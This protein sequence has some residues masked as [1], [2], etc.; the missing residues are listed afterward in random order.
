[1]NQAG[2]FG[3]RDKGSRRNIAQDGVVPAQQHFRTDQL[4]GHAH[5]RLEIQRKLIVFERAAQAAFQFESAIGVVLHVRFEQSC[6]VA[7][8]LGTIH[9]N[10]GTAQDVG[11]ILRP[12]GKCRHADACA[13]AEGAAI[14]GQRPCQSFNQHFGNGQGV[15]GNVLFGGR[16]GFQQHDEL[17]AAKPRDGRSGR[18]GVRKMTGDHLK[19]A[20]ADLMA[21]ASLI[22]LKLSRSISNTA[23]TWPERAVSDSMSPRMTMACCKLGKPV[24][25]SWKAA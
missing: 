1:M 21:Q 5:V 10:V 17:V 16:G 9:R 24:S 12:V 4:A 6:R 15:F 2:F 7:P 23:P 14:D 8:G 18:R 19:H 11:G 13:N 3:D 22:V 20:I 25:A